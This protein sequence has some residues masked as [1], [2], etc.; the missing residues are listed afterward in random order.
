MTNVCNLEYRQCFIYRADNP[1]LARDKMDDPTMLHQLRM[2]KN[3]TLIRSNV[4]TLEM[5]KSDRAL[6][7]TGEHGEHCALRVSSCSPARPS[8]NSLAIWVEL[9]TETP[10][11][12]HSLSSDKPVA[13][14]N[15]CV[16]GCPDLGVHS[17][18]RNYFAKAENFP[19]ITGKRPW[20]HSTSQ[21]SAAIC[22]AFKLRK[23]LV[24]SLLVCRLAP[25]QLDPG[26]R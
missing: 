2:R 1:N 25:N 5:M 10:M 15:S 3:P 24:S 14:S 7:C 16:P 26:F 21:K 19:G 23:L 6:N 20:V 8:R 13:R 18:T 4:E 11:P 17:R 22:V 12:S 9:R